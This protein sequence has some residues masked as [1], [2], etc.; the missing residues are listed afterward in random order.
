MNSCQLHYNPKTQHP[1]QYS[2]GVV[3]IHNAYQHL[4]IK[5]ESFSSIKKKIRFKNNVGTTVFDIYEYLINNKLKTH[6]YLFPKINDI[7]KLIKTSAL[8]ARLKSNSGHTGHIVN[9]LKIDRKFV[10]ISNSSDD[11]NLYHPIHRI[12][13]KNFKERYNYIIATSKF[14]THKY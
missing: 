7:K 9:V 11:N 4:G 1:Y 3:A 2:C 8:I 12:T 13:L 14:K 10:Y 6:I 5:P